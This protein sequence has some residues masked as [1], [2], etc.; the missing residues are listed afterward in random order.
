MRSHHP[1][2]S[3]CRALF[4]ALYVSPHTVQQKRSTN[5][6]PVSLYNHLPQAL[7]P[8]GDLNARTFWSIPFWRCSVGT[9]TDPNVD[10]KGFIEKVIL[11]LPTK[12]AVNRRNVS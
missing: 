7:A 8:K 9:C 11:T 6:T 4:Q 5:A 1:V 2:S 3:E 12:L 10:D